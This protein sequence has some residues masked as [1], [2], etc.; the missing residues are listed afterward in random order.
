MV[1]TFFQQ[2]ANIDVHMCILVVFTLFSMYFLVLNRNI[3]VSC[4][5]LMPITSSSLSP[6]FLTS[7]SPNTI[8][9][10]EEWSFDNFLITRSFNSV[11]T[12]WLKHFVRISELMWF[13]C[14]FQVC[15]FSIY[16]L[17]VLNR[18]AK[19][20]CRNLVH[21]ILKPPVVYLLISNWSPNLWAFWIPV[22]NTGQHIVDLLFTLQ[23]E[24][25]NSNSWVILEWLVITSIFRL[26]V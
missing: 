16:L 10:R 1:E 7:N 13:T 14:A 24:A 20:S 3:K 19:S 25:Q 17:F 18:N 22:I 4:V 9:K 26:S 21:Y 15:L 5:N 2:S 23:L 6:N 11:Q 8:Y 12:K